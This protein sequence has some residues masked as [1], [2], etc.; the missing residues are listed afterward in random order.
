MK[1]LLQKVNIDGHYVINKLREADIRC[2]Y[3]IYCKINKDWPNP[4]L[5]SYK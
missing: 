4:E 5:P 2:S 3:M 1:T